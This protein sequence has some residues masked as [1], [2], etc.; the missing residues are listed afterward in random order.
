MLPILAARKV[1]LTRFRRFFSTPSPGADDI[2]VLDEIHGMRADLAQLPRAPR[3][4][5][6][7]LRPRGRD[8]EAGV[9]V[10]TLRA[11]GRV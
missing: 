9:R 1:P 2:A 10:R 8:G 3:R 6:G 5:Q 11:T 4:W 7:E